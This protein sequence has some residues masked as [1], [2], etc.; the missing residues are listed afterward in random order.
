VHARTTAVTVAALLLAGCSSSSS[1]GA[2]AK[3]SATT[4]AA[5]APTADGTTSAPAAPTTAAAPTPATPEDKI[6]AIADQHGWTLGETG[7]DI[8]DTLYGGDGALYDSPAA[9]VQDICDSLPDQE[10]DGPAQWLAEVQAT[11]ADQMNIL[12]AGVPLLCPQWTATVKQAASGKYPV[13]MGEGTYMVTSK[14]GPEN[15]PPGTYR[16]TGDLSGCY[17][18]RTKANGDIIDNNFATHA[19]K[20]TVTIRASDDSFTSQGCGTWKPIG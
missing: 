3:P 16:T 9:F 7:D 17:W 13:F 8:D 12:V 20:I 2:A 14:R 5:A 1:D 10:E 19:S 6:N 4:S 18:E 15:V 11:T